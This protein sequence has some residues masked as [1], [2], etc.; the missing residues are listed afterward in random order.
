MNFDSAGVVPGHIGVGLQN[1][2]F[3]I[4]PCVV[5]QFWFRFLG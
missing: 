2:N 1:T 4:S 3:G 5:E